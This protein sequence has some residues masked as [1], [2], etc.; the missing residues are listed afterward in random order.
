[1]ASMYDAMIGAAPADGSP[2]QAAIADALRRRAQRGAV[3]I[4]SND[5]GMAAQGQMMQNDAMGAAKLMAGTREHG[6]DDTQTRRYQDWQ[7][8]QAADNLAERRRENT[9]MDRYR[10]AMAAAQAD[11]VAKIPDGSAAG[12]KAVEQEIRQYSTKMDS[13]GLTELQKA[14]QNFRDLTKP[15]Q[16]R[17]EAVP[18][19]G[20]SSGMPLANAFQGKDAQ[21]IQGA[22]MAIKNGIM[23]ARSGLAVTVPEAERLASEL[24]QSVLHSEDQRMGALNRIESLVG[25]RA[26]N[27]QTI[28]SPAALE[29][30]TKRRGRTG[31]T[32]TFEIP[33]P[34]GG[35]TVV[36]FHQLPAKRGM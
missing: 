10:S 6:I 32:G 13:S 36:D 8:Q 30:Y 31:A 12:N 14:I 3:G 5:P 19:M 20:R 35:G 33:A 2:Q 15:Y 23:R 18:G 1:M 11:K 21:D 24:E 7:E 9:L 16:D 28:L 17:G 29:E 27:M 25:D 34:T 4:I 22:L 26:A